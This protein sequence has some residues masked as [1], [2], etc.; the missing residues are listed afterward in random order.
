MINLL[1]KK[2][3][4]PTTLIIEIFQWSLSE[5]PVVASRAVQ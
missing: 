1:A 4:N 2:K 3:I 5:I